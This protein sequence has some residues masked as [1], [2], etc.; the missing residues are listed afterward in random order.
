MRFRITRTST[1]W[2]AD[3]E[4]PPVRGAVKGTIPYWDLRTFKSAEEYEANLRE[5]WLDRG[6]EHQ[7]SRSGGIKRRIKEGP[8]WFID[9]PDLEALVQLTEKHGDVVL[10][11]RD[12]HHGDTPT[13]EIYDEGR[14][15]R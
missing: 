3:N 11:T 2:N 12:E 1:R 7:P 5:R 13:I 4:P 14:E 8:A 6:T 10:W 15:P 9:V